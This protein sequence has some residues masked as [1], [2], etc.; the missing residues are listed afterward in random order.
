MN[1]KLN[2]CLKIISILFFVKIL[3]NNTNLFAQNH[4]TI[5]Y[6]DY[7]NIDKKVLADFE[8][9]DINQFT[10]NWFNI[11]S[12]SITQLSKDYKNK[13]EL[14]IQ[15]R[16][17]DIQ[18]PYISMELTKFGSGITIYL[19]FYKD[20]HGVHKNFQASELQKRN[21]D[22]VDDKIKSLMKNFYCE[23]FDGICDEE[24]RKEN[25]VIP[26]KSTTKDNNDNKKN[27]LVDGKIE[28]E[29]TPKNA[30]TKDKNHSEKYHESMLELL[31]LSYENKVSSRDTFV[32][33]IDKLNENMKK[34]QVNLEIFM[35]S[36]KILDIEHRLAKKE[37]YTKDCETIENLLKEINDDILKPEE[38]GV[39]DIEIYNRINGRKKKPNTNK[40]FKNFIDELEKR[41]NNKCKKQKYK[42]H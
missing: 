22:P 23:F 13:K 11:F 7:N 34:D 27:A 3:L 39:G 9:G 38:M 20:N 42:K 30:T 4:K 14:I 18:F 17:Y 28:N 33:K 24:K 16:K 35:I 21:I 12:S 25:K 15:D 10:K 37:L 2:E 40:N 19:K 8:L 31:D 29:I 6:L 5:I 26:E 32:G 36:K 41:K 1:I